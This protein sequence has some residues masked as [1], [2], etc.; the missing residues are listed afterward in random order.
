MTIEKAILNGSQIQIEALATGPS[1]NA[2]HDHNKVILFVHGMGR[3]PLSA[4]PVLRRLRQ[5]QL[6]TTT[7]AYVTA[8]ENFAAIKARLVARIVSLAASGSYVVVGHSLGGVL[9]RAA[10]NALPAETT[11][12]KH[13]FLL[14]SPIQ[15]S[16]LAKRLKEN[17]LY[18]VLTGDC[19]QLLSS[20]QR[21]AEVG[22]LNDATTSIVG[23]RG[24]AA[25]RHFF[26]AEANDGVVSASETDAPWIAQ[27]RP[28]AIL[29]SLLPS[30]TRVANI[31]IDELGKTAGKPSGVA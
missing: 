9:L 16:R 30:S 17:L 28:V 6:T 3:S 18:R 23:V 20:P 31:I 13:V 11:R 15:A 1:A 8:F 29:H 26:G 19:G 25:T 5:A 10:L 24:I 27:K 12:P 2:E 14:G 7:F 4:W 22:A 21:M